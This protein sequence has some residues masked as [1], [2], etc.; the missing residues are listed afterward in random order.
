M[1][2]IIDNGECYSSHT[3]YFV[4]SKLSQNH[5][6][7]LIELECSGGE[8]LATS[9][10]FNWYN[11]KPMNDYEFVFAHKYL[12]QTRDDYEVYENV[13]TLPKEFLKKVLNRYR[14]N[15]YWYK[16]LKQAFKKAGLI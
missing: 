12:N 15:E 10:K 1:I 16:N 7:T 9:N 8:I 14:N 5:I 13:K 4:E 11:G 6:K 2:Y 3:I